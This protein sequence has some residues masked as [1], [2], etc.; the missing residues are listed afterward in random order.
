[1]RGKRP[2]PTLHDVARQQDPRLAQ[3]PLSA[4]QALV[5]GIN[6]LVWRAIDDGRSARLG[7]LEDEIL[8]FVLVAYLGAADAQQELEARVTERASLHAPRA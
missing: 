5:G 8:H 2:R 4:Y 7:E 6:D 1:M 3:L